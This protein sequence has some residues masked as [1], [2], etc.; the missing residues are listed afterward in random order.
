MCVFTAFFFFFSFKVVEEEC[1]KNVLLVGG[2]K[3][4]RMFQECNVMCR[5]K[6][7]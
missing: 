5:G 4:G 7:G 1:S 6:E 3:K 2:E